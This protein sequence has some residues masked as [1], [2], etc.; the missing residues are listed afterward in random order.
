MMTVKTF[1]QD[2]ILE[3]D[4]GIYVIPENSFC[5]I[6]LKRLNRLEIIAS[7]NYDLSVKVNDFFNDLIDMY[8]GG[9]FDEN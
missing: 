2:T 6:N 5:I 3:A 1:F 9:R 4:V 8:E 7:G